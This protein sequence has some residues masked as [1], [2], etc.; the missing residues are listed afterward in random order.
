M[1]PTFSFEDVIAWQK[2]HAFTLL[3]YQLTPEK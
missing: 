3:V 2:A 1:K